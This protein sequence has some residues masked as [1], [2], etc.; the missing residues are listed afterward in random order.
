LKFADV[1]SSPLN[2]HVTNITDNSVTVSWLPPL[3]DGGAP[4]MG[5]LIET[6]FNGQSCW[7]KEIS[8]DANTL[9]AE[10]SNLK[11]GEFYFVHVYAFNN[12]GISRKA[13][14]LFEPIFCSKPKKPRNLKILNVE[15][16]SVT[17]SWEKPKH[18]GGYPIK[19]YRVDVSTTTQPEWTTVALTDENPVTRITGMPVGDHCSLRVTAVNAFGVNSK[20]SVLHQPIKLFSDFFYIKLMINKFNFFLNFY[21]TVFPFPEN[22]KAVL[23]YENR[24][25][26]L[27]WDSKILKMAS[28][29]YQVPN[30]IIET[31]N[32][33]DKHWNEKITVNMDDSGVELS[34][35][36]LPDS[37][38][39]RIL[40][41]D[42]VESDHITLSWSP[43]LDTGNSKIKYYIIVMKENDE[44]KFKKIGKVDGYANTF[45]YTKIK[46]GYLY[47]FRVYAENDLGISKEFSSFDGYVRI[48]KTEKTSNDFAEVCAIIYIKQIKLKIHVFVR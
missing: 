13:C 29:P 3:Y 16:G 27:L 4:L 48:P 9:E 31:R 7:R 38:R 10:I 28:L 12:Q 15:D 5:Y 22:L 25:T 37:Y 24:Q 44:T 6:C 35:H 30:Y 46:P 42:D 23:N 45:N 19:E 14:D 8:T 32:I 21:L 11:Q 2:L 20:P 39:V 36:D 43:P 41:L 47:S 40:I 18:D 33:N 17:V 26:S 1:P 34:E